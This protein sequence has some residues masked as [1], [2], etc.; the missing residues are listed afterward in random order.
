MGERQGRVKEIYFSLNVVFFIPE[1]KISNS[2]RVFLGYF[3]I[4]FLQKN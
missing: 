3:I 2:D 4:L 1:N